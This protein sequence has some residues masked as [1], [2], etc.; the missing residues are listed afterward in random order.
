MMKEKDVIITARKRRRAPRVAA[1]SMVAPRAR[2][3][4]ANSTIR[5][6]FF[7][8]SAMSTTTP[9][10]A[11]TSLGSPAIQRP[12]MAPATPMMTETSTAA[13]IAQLS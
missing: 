3:S 4:I 10:C 2:A 9:I 12:A 13:G 8:A 11:K 6:A 1:S 5:M 7:A